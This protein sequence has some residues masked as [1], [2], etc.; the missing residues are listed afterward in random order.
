MASSVLSLC[1]DHQTMEL[2]RDWGYKQRRLKIN[3]I[4]DY[5]TEYPLLP[6]FNAKGVHF[7]L[8]IVYVLTPQTQVACC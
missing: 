3:R 8:L 7:K 4:K 1:K 6:E 5:L 2:S